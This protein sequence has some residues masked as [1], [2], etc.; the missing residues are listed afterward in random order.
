MTTVLCNSNYQIY[1]EYT[2]VRIFF[3]EELKSESFE[4]PGMKLRICVASCDNQIVRIKIFLAQFSTNV[5]DSC[6]NTAITVRTFPRDFVG[7]SK[8][9][10]GKEKVVKA[11]SV[12]FPQFRLFF[13]P[14]GTFFFERNDHCCRR[15]HRL[16]CDWIDRCFENLDGFFVARQY[17]E[18]MDLL[19][20]RIR[21]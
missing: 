11:W 17:D 21:L 12:K 7:D 8:R 2:T 15:W 6:S 18:V 5:S 13:W 4:K 19:T 14:V 1:L 3:I 20:A 9:M 16:I 10:N